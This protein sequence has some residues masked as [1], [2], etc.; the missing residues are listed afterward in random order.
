MELE[1]WL[2]SYA[3]RGGDHFID[4]NDDLRVDALIVF[5]RVQGIV[6]ASEGLKENQ[7]PQRTLSYTKELLFDFLREPLCP[8]WFMI[9]RLPPAQPA[10]T[11]SSSPAPR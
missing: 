2:G 4:R 10:P 6:A 11:L 3:C 9:F 5:S 8:L 1:D 7:E